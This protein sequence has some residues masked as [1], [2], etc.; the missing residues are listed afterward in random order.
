MK[1]LL[2]VICLAGLA[3]ATV[4]LAGAQG[5]DAQPAFVYGINAA[6]PTT[7]VGTFAPP[8]DDLYLLA[9]RV[10]VISPR[11]TR[12][13]FWPITNEYR[14]D[15]TMKNDPVPGTLEVLHNG[16]VVA[17]LA[18]TDYTIHFTQADGETS[19][20]IFLGEEAVAAEEEFRARQQAFQEASNAYYDAQRAWLDAAAAANA[21]I[22]AGEEPGEIPPEPAL[23]EPIGVFSNGLNQGFPIDLDPGAF[24]IRLRAPDG[25]IV[26]DSERNLT[27]FAARRT[28]VGY[29]VVPETRWTTPDDSFAR[30][31]V[32]FG[33][34]DSNLYL[35]PRVA[36]EYP[37]RAWALLQNPQTPAGGAGGWQ[38]V[39]GE[40]LADGVLEVIHD[41]RIAERR[42][43]TPYRVEQ[44]PGRQLGYTV[45]DL[46]TTPDDTDPPD[47]A[48]YPIALTNG[49]EQYQVRLVTAQGE[50]MAGSERQVR[51]AASLPVNRVFLLPLAPLAI[52]AA[53]GALR[54]RRITAARDLPAAG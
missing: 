10:S 50:V 14:A 7:F 43:L 28:G 39:S 30:D 19:A 5:A 41:G 6:V 42:E 4:S 31:D 26:P 22:K 40:R 32:I 1:C 46:S 29:S 48:A 21:R 23:P 11:E 3:V 51:V 45:V 53:I 34:A 33:A 20:E 2:V 24:R 52:G 38:W 27:V 18:S 44:T 54:G 8:G 47:F 36:L 9:D 13:S 49:G 17:E 16:A 15:W 37:A 25:A 12:I 35:E